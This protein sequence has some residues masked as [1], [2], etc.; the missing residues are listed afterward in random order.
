VLV[1]IG[2][3]NGFGQIENG[4]D[5]GFP[6]RGTS[7]FALT[8]GDDQLIFGSH[9]VMSVEAMCSNARD[10][11]GSIKNGFFTAEKYL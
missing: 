4:V 8:K 2:S 6:L 11:S 1:R 3:E 10:D 9:Q 7:R 5:W